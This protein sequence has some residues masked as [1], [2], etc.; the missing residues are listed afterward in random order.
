MNRSVKYTIETSKFVNFAES[1]NKQISNITVT[2]TT[3]KNK[4][5]LEALK[6]ERKFSLMGVE[7]GDKGTPRYKYE[8]WTTM[9][10]SKDSFIGEKAEKPLVFRQVTEVKVQAI[11]GVGGTVDAEVTEIIKLLKPL[12]NFLQETKDNRL[13][14]K[15]QNREGLEAFDAKTTEFII[16]INKRVSKSKVLNGN[17][18]SI[19]DFEE[20]KASIWSKQKVNS[21]ICSASLCCNFLKKLI[22]PVLTVAASFAGYYYGIEGF[23]IL[24]VLIQCIIGSEMRAILRTLLTAEGLSES[25]IENYIDQYMAVAEKNPQLLN[26]KTLLNVLQKHSNLGWHAVGSALSFCLVVIW[27]MYC[28]HYIIRRVLSN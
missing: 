15:N 14:E 1:V 19:K 6:S 24:K 16:E 17:Q 18:L 26:A 7:Y 2:V 27:G 3:N 23:H 20:I 13:E 4:Q 10:F 8:I 22:F 12:N 9:Q 5:G 11:N 28:M 21:C 25:A